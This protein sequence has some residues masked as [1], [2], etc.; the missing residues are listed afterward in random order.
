MTWHWRYKYKDRFVVWNMMCKAQS[1]NP[2]LYGDGTRHLSVHC[3]PPLYRKSYSIVLFL[4]SS[5]FWTGFFGDPFVKKNTDLKSS[6]DTRQ[7]YLS[8]VIKGES[9]K[10]TSIP[11]PK[12]QLKALLDELYFIYPCRNKYLVNKISNDEF[13]ILKNNTNKNIC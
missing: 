10:L 11:N 12:S 6:S 3:N 9:K 7:R 8:E 5:V 2:S 4:R 1:A 13:T